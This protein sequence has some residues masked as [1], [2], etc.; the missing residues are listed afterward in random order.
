MHLVVDHKQMAIGIYHCLTDGVQTAT[1]STALIIIDIYIRVFYFSNAELS[2]E[3]VAN[4]HMQFAG[5]ILEKPPTGNLQST[6]HN[7]KALG[8]TG[9]D[10]MEYGCEHVDA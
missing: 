5:Q 4:I 9:C 3:T 7:G 1:V 8:E 2:G 6:P 10:H